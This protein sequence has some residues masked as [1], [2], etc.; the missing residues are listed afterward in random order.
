MHLCRSV[1]AVDMGWIIKSDSV[2]FT[3]KDAS[4]IR[5]QDKHNVQQPDAVHFV[6]RH[7]QA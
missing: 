6:S 7:T 4:D 5:Q 3:S 1:F 2:E